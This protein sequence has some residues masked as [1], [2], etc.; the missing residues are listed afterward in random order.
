MGDAEKY[1]TIRYAS[2]SSHWKTGKKRPVPKW[3]R[4]GLWETY[5]GDNPLGMC[6]CCKEPFSIKNMQA[7][8]TLSAQEGGDI[9]LE[10]L[11]PVC[12]GCNYSMRTRKLHEWMAEK[13]PSPEL[14]G[15]LECCKLVYLN[16]VKNGFG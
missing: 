8:H 10:N 4:I 16:Y 13:Y 14:T 9:S 15:M 3:M 7:G 5:F 1:E 11:R 6:Y 2:I 12:G